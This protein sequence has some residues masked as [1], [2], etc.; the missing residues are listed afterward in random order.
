MNSIP[1]ENDRE[2]RD[3]IDLACAGLADELIEERAAHDDTRR[4]LHWCRDAI[5][6]AV[7]MIHDLT[8]KLRRRQ[9]INIR[10]RREVQQLRDALLEIEGAPDPE[11]QVNTSNHL[12]TEERTH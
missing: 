11:A 2:Y 5:K 8:E 10:L 9:D 6:V 4:E 3:H 12:P 1:P 7:A